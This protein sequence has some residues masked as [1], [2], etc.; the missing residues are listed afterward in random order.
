MT[1][2]I[3]SQTPS[4]LPN[5]KITITHKINKNGHSEIDINANSIEILTEVLTKIQDT[6]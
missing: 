2:K 1:L 3:I 5:T 4:K 6:L